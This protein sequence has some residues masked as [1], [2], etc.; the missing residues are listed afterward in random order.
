MNILEDNYSKKILKTWT[1]LIYANGN[2]DLEPEISKSLLDIERIG[3]GKN[4]NVIIQLARA[5]YKLVK[6]M[7]PHKLVPTNVDGDW[8]GVRRYLV[9]E[10]SD[11]SE[12][13][14]FTSMLLDDLGN[15]NMAD[16]T[17]LYDFICWGIKEFPAKHFMLI[18]VGHGAGFMG[19]LPDY[20]L[21]SPQIMSINGVNVAINKAVKETGKKIDI[22]LF[23][24]CYMNMIEIV[25]EL[26]IN[27]KSPKYLITPQVSPIEGLPYDIIM[28]VIRE[29]GKENNASIL[30]KDLTYEVDKI[31]NKQ[32]IS[33]LGFRLNSLLLKCIKIVISK[34]SALVIKNNLD[35]KKYAALSYGGFPSINIYYLPH[36]LRNITNSFAMLIKTYILNLCTKFITLNLNVEKSKVIEN[37]SILIFTPDSH[38]LKL[39]EKYYHKMQFIQNNKWIKYLCGKNEYFEPNKATFKY[40]LPPSE[41][42]P[43]EGILN[44]IISH[45]PR[46]SQE[47]LEKVI[48]DLGWS[49]CIRIK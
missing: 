17:T 43:L 9:K 28:K 31:L 18:L 26:G 10:D 37:K 15:V 32:R 47:D 11:I 42:M 22:L 13:R 3:T 36:I 29:R 12:T 33:L 40:V 14:D 19:I 44:V 39:V 8:S 35:I 20:T 34:V 30:I 38:Y 6:I 27:L 5:P 23:D 24:S 41:D 2:N 25:Y 1:V 4:V 21:T 16:P 48:E 49:S 45:N 46:L 7:R